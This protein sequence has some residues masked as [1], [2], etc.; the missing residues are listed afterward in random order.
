Q[1]LWMGPFQCLTSNS[2]AT[3]LRST[4]TVMYGT[5]CWTGSR[6][7]PP[8]PWPPAT[9]CRAATQTVRR[10]RSTANPPSNCP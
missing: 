6:R 8:W 2:T 3:P 7:R 1:K 5:A 4:S 10:R 9:L